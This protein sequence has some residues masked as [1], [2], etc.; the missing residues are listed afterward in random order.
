MEGR[1]D[2]RKNGR[3]AGSVTISLRN[4]VGEG[5]NIL[6]IKNRGRLRPGVLRNNVTLLT[7]LYVRI[8]SPLACGKHLYDHIISLRGQVWAHITILFPPLF[9]IRHVP[10][11]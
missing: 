9:I 4:F 6:C 11:Q 5:I 7:Q 10:V 8:H 2:G 3:T 1:T